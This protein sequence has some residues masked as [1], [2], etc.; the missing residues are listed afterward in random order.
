MLLL[1]AYQFDRFTVLTNL[2]PKFPGEGA[3]V[4]GRFDWDLIPIL[5][6]A[7]SPRCT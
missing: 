7:G 5:S 4:G 2:K 6:C 3:L 1:G